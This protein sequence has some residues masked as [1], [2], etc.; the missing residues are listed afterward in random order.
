MRMQTVCAAHAHKRTF[1]LWLMITDRMADC[2]EPWS[3]YRLFFILIF[4]VMKMINNRNNNNVYYL[5]DVMQSVWWMIIIL[6][7]FFIYEMCDQKRSIFFSFCNPKLLTA[8]VVDLFSFWSI[9][10]SYIFFFFF[11]LICNAHTHQNTNAIHP[12]SL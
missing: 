5:D 9:S 3:S 12:C 2:L 8:V 4:L 7:L 6:L 1:D 10:R 11:F